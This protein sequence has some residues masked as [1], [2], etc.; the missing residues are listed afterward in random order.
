MTFTMKLNPQQMQAVTAEVGPILVLAGAG[1]G[2][3]RVLTHRIEHLVKNCGVNPYNVLAIT[4]T[5]KAANEMKTRLYDSNCNAGFMHISTIHSFCASV[6]RREAAVLNKQTTFSI[7]GDDEKRSILKRVVKQMVEDTE[8]ALVDKVCDTL[9]YLKNQ[10][11]YVA[12]L[13]CEVNQQVVDEVLNSD[14]ADYISESME[15]VS[16]IADEQKYL[17]ILAEYNKKMSEN[18]AM[19]FDD[20]LFYVHKLFSQFPEVLAKYQERYQHILIDEFQ[21]TNKVQYQIFKMLAGNTQSLFVVGDDDQSIY[22]WRGADVT[23]ILNFK[24]DFP[25]AQV[26]K[27]EQN[28]RSTKRILDTANEIISVNTKRFPK[29]LWTE[30]ADGNKT[31][32]FQAYDEADEAYHAA[33]VI[34]RG[35]SLGK[36][37]SDYAILMR[38]NA[39]SRSFEQQF[40]RYRIPF[41]VFGGFKFFDRKEVKDALAY[42]RLIVNPFDNEAFMR[43]INVP[44]RRGIGDTT[45]AKLNDISMQLCIP[46]FSVI[47]DERNMQ[48]VIGKATITKLANFYQEVVELMKVANSNNVAI[49]MH[50]LLQRLEFR[51]VYMQ[52]GEDER[53][54][55]IDELEQ[56][57]IEFQASFPEGTL[58]DYLQNVSLVADRVSDNVKDDN[59]VTIATIHAVKGLEFD[60]VFV[61]GLESGIFPSSRSTYSL[62]DME[63]ENRVM[64][65][66]AT[67]AKRDLHLTCSKTRF[68]Y[69]QRK[70]QFPSS[71]FAK[72]KKMLT[73]APKVS[74]SRLDDNNYVDSLNKFSPVQRPP[75][76]KGKSDKDMKQFKVGQMVEH[77]TFGKGMI[78]RYDN[79]IADV[80]FTSV[81]KKSLNV[82]FA[83]L[84]PL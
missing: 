81:G 36:K 45:L 76:D 20:L 18:N 15:S 3:T 83:P 31:Q 40:M 54:M 75:V 11:S 23:H 69:G 43:A 52:N 5:N 42:A 33:E 67:R 26:F 10:G 28:Y 70:Q 38:I 80:L 61:V 68:L 24:K 34:Q 50:E 49:F 22:S 37:Y 21:D 55:N 25:S 74:Q 71:Y 58:Q 19:D 9:S 48:D 66:A 59:Y 84:K 53:A 65:V 6:L 82:K 63:E 30:N 1:S 35:V 77:S 64:Y 27:L 44:C 73:P 12:G 16:D 41:K 8:N 13:N 62:S 14:C 32:L 56:S 4:F 79:G 57:A 47:S 60:T 78:L 2:K 46:L 39:L 72:I 17:S 7:Y 51:S 29:T